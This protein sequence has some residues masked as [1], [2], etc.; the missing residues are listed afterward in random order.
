MFPIT[1]SGGRAASTVGRAGRSGA[2]WT[3]VQSRIAFH[4]N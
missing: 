1:L 3:A 4:I 2:S